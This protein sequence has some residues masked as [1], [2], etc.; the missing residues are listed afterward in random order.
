MRLRN[1]LMMTGL[2]VLALGTFSCKKNNPATSSSSSE[3]QTTATLSAD[4]AV[5][6]NLN[7]DAENILTEVTVDNNLSGNTPTGINGT[8]G[9]LPS[10]AAVTVTPAQGFPKNISIDF[11]S[12]CTSPSGI[13]RSGIINIS[14]SD[15]LRKSGSVA[16]MTFQNYY[17]SGFK[18]EGTI[19]WTNTKQDTTNSWIRTCQGGKITAPD[20]SYWTHS[21]TDTVVQ[22]NGNNT[23]GNITDNVYL[24]TGTS[25]VANSAG[26]SRTA[27]ILTPL[28]K[29]VA[30]DNIDSGSIK[31]QGPSHYATIDFGDGTCDRLATVSIDGGIPIQILLR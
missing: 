28:E 2:S 7:S 22:I 20:G 27:T 16:V 5:S 3:I 25:T 17:V 14:L 12:G 9:Y 15:S 23:P 11:G 4:M 19:T 1:I 26:V 13:T 30:C 21:G 24:T 18:K 31:I 10:C 29:K 6:N 8:A